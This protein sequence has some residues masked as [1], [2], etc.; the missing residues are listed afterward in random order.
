MDDLSERLRCLLNQ[1]SAENGSNT[2]DFILAAYL[3]ACLDAFDV[4]VHDRDV[5]YGRA[6]TPKDGEA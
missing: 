4:A 3:L 6:A 1:E 2:P 5:W